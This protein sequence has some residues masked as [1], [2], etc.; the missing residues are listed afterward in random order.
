MGSCALVSERGEPG[1][2]PSARTRRCDRE[3]NSV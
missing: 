1:V 2:D 3:R